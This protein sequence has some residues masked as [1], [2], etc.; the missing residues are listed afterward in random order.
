[1]MKFPKRI[2]CRREPDGQLNF[3]ET[4]LAFRGRREHIAVYEFGGVE[5]L[6]NLVEGQEVTRQAESGE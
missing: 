3:S 6:T 4:L 5:E 1:M 2:Y